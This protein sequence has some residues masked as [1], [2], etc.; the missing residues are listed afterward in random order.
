MLEQQRDELAAA[1]AAALAGI[2][3]PEARVALEVPP[4]RQL[5]DLAWAGALP[6]AKA[7]KRPPREIAEEVARAVGERL[8]A[9]RP[10]EALA[11]LEPEAAVE[12]PGFLNFR[13][14]RGPALAALLTEHEELWGRRSAPAVR[15]E[16][17]P[18][19]VIVEHTNINPNK[20]A[21]IGHL[22]NA[23]LGDTLVR[24]LRFAGHDVEVQN[25]LDDTGV[26][27]A[28]VVVGFVHLPED[29]L[30]AAVMPVWPEVTRGDGTPR[31]RVLATLAARHAAGTL[32]SAEL[33][34]AD[35]DDL[36]WDLYPRVT[37]RYEADPTFAAYRTEVLHAIEGGFPPD[38]SLEQAVA[39]LLQP[40][41]GSRTPGRSGGWP[42]RSPRPTCVATC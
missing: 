15:A 10:S 38:L 8:A 31:A 39:L 42:L 1:I 34:A 23:V 9:A 7:L 14:R 21:H 35:F 33:G 20:A 22:R 4:R 40:D 28:D 27:V 19:K 17:V 12:G 26:Q 5:G 32:V 6:L 18:H 41:A 11:L 16:R 30:L 29:A 25:Y 3:A 13:L 37:A 36:C 24:C 2:G